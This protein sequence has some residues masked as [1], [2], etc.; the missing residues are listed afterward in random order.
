MMENNMTELTIPQVAWLRF[1]ENKQSHR[2][3]RMLV[4]AANHGD[5]DRAEV[6]LSILSAWGK[7]RKDPARSV[8]TTGIAE[9]LRRIKTGGGAALALNWQLQFFEVAELAIRT[10]IGPST[11]RKDGYKLQPQRGRL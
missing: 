5:A 6:L 11:G 2:A 8:S 10:D 4:S 1:A 3:W 7:T 9:A